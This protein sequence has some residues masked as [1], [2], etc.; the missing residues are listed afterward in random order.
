MDKTI[1]RKFK[2]GE[3]IALFPQIT[4]GKFGWHCESYM[5]T[6][7]HGAASPD[8]VQC[9]KPA[10]P[11]EYQQLHKELEQIGY[12]PVP[13]LKFTYKDQLIRASQRN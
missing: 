10:T 9:T 8:I 5:H 13:A 6:G 11:V 4:A 2:G 1:Y 12:N 7:Q 3:V